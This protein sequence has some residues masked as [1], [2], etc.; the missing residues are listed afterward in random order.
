M[1]KI[2]K[3]IED[4]VASHGLIKTHSDD[5]I[6]GILPI[7]WQERA[8]VF[9]FAGN[10]L[11]TLVQIAPLP[12]DPKQLRRFSRLVSKLGHTSRLFTH[13]S[14]DQEHVYWT[15]DVLVPIC[16]VTELLEQWF[17]HAQA[18]IVEVDRML[19]QAEGRF[20]DS[21][22]EIPLQSIARH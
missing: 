12:Q 3:C 6:Y 9:G 17:A 1:L 15:Y 13:L 7:G 8:C 16:S 10:P 5:S 22:F 20:T 2:G 14:S 4:F 21:A 18:D 19:F 11:R